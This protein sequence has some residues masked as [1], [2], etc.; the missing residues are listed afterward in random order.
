MLNRE[1]SGL[2]NQHL[3]PVGDVDRLPLNP[4]IKRQEYNETIIETQSVRRR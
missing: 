3:Y 4:T 2:G 1:Y